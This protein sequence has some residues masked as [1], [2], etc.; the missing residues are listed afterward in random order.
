[1]LSSDSEDDDAYEASDASNEPPY[2]EIQEPMAVPDSRGIVLPPNPNSAIAGGISVGTRQIREAVYKNY[3]EA[4]GKQPR[5]SQ[6]PKREASKVSNR[7]LTR[8]SSSNFNAY[9]DISLDISRH[10][11]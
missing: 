6:L 5:V 7:E 1:M 3:E 11:R 8:Q 10:E 4:V 9:S 2:L